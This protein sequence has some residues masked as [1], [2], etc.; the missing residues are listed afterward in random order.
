[1]LDHIMNAMPTNAVV[2]RKMRAK[3]PMR[4]FSSSCMDLMG[5]SSRGHVRLQRGSVTNSFRPA[6]LAAQEGASAGEGATASGNTIPAKS[7]TPNGILFLQHHGTTDV[8]KYRGTSVQKYISFLN[9][10][11]S[12]GRCTRTVAGM[13]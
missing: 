12:V 6:S 13:Q 3:F 4:I 5:A 9:G 11:S 8:L 2:A 1:M 10:F 7:L